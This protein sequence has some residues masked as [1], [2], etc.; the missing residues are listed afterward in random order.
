[1]GFIGASLRSP[2]LAPTSSL[3]TSSSSQNGER[4]SGACCGHS[5]SFWLESIARSKRS[6][7]ANASGEIENLEKVGRTWRKIESMTLVLMIA[8]SKRHDNIRW[9][10]RSRSYNAGAS[11]PS[12]FF[13]ERQIDEK[14]KGNF[15]EVRRVPAR[16]IRDVF[17]LR[18]GRDDP[19]FFPSG[20]ELLG[21]SE[22]RQVGITSG[23]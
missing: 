21:P 9:M 8:R 11:G 19:P 22:R 14:S 16:R 2:P 17:V 20:A 18:I 23:T 6:S 1:M 5:T 3:T 13:E 4:T 15:Q 7:V 10:S 12:P